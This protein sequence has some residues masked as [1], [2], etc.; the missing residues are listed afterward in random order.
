MEE[1]GVKLASSNL[2]QKKK[3]ASSKLGKEVSSLH[4]WRPSPSLR[5]LRLAWG[6][7]PLSSFRQRGGA[8]G[9]GENKDEGEVWE[10]FRPT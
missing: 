5:R 8:S 3:I 2:F 7:P 6:A 10:N 1:I 9:G 4:D